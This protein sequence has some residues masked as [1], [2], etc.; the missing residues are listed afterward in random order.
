MIVNKT[1]IFVTLALCSFLATAKEVI[2]IDTSHSPIYSLTFEIERTINDQNSTTVYV[3]N[4]DES[5]VF[6]LDSRS[7]YSKV[8]IAPISSG[9]NNYN[10]ALD[11]S[12]KLD[13]LSNRRSSNSV[14]IGG[15]RH[16]TKE[17]HSVREGNGVTT[18]ETRVEWLTLEKY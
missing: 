15:K 6:K 10:I 11:L 12:F 9:S 4:M 13:G 14:M 8:D 3:I 7:A 17:G 16:K 1:V 5:A 2:T 18:E